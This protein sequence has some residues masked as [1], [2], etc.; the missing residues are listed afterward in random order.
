MSDMKAHIDIAVDAAIVLSLLWCL[1]TGMAVEL[2]APVAVLL[3][4]VR[5]GSINRSLSDGGDDDR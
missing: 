3:C 2:V 1:W 5:L 4:Y